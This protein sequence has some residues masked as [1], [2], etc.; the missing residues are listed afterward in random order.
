MFL[1]VRS[2]ETLRS[3]SWAKQLVCRV[4]ACL[5]PELLPCPL[6]ALPPDAP[7][8]RLSLLRSNMWCGN[9]HYPEPPPTSQHSTAL[10]TTILWTLTDRQTETVT[11]LED[12]FLFPP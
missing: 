11:C 3:V 9:R 6:T 4:P 2:D 7:D 10:G 5:C 1:Y 8:K 12:F